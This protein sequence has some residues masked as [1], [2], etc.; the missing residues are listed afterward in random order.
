MVERQLCK[1]DVRGS[2]PL[3]SMNSGASRNLMTGPGTKNE[4]RL[5]VRKR[6]AQRSHFGRARRSRDNPLA[7]ISDGGDG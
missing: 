4:V 3:A 1:L 6:L 7:S 5:P 2:S